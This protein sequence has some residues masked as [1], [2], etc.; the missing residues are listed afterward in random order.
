VMRQGTPSIAAGTRRIG[1][2][3][4][5]FIVAEVGA[6]HDGDVTTAHRLVDIAADGGADA[7]KFQTY[8]AAELVADGD[9]E[10][11]WG[12]AA[13]QRR[14]RIGALFDRLALPRAA[15]AELFAHARERGLIPFSTPFSPG[16][17]A[18]LAELGVA[19]LK[20]ASS[21]I[22][23]ADLLDA[24]A[25]ADIPVVL[26]SGKSRLGEVDDAVERLSTG[27][28]AGIALLHCVAQYPAPLNEMHLRTIPA[29]AAMYP[30]CPIGLSDH[31]VGAVAALGAV[32]L[33][34]AIVE[35]HITFDRAAEGPDH[36]FSDGPDELAALVN[37]I[38]ALE[39]ALGTPGKHVQASERHERRVSTR[40]LVLARPVAAGTPLCS[41]DL[42]V[43]RPGWGIHPGDYEKVL[44]LRPTRAL[45]SGEV[46]TWEH[47][48]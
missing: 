36:W 17:V 41:E 45:R 7:V 24:A 48:R 35:R 18:F 19:L 46:L 5:V 34:A 8:T 27:G 37:D 25:E 23:Y 29:L 9:R 21:D 33:G 4:P 11:V 6:N 43:L 30:R 20:I 38:R 1:A 44:G 40:S 10:I 14:E 13:A 15:H 42:Q 31:S 3:E 12:P 16:G 39:A 22:A 47:F 26:S 28:A 2:G 32:A